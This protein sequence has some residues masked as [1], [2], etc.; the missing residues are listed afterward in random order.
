MGEKN[1]QEE[2]LGEE[3][4]GGKYMGENMCKKSFWKNLWV[5]RKF[6]KKHVQ[7]ECLG[8]MYMGVSARRITGCKVYG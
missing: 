5:T 3:F 7:K 4:L 2:F 8:E 1:L 6:A